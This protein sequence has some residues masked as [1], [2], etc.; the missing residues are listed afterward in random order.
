MELDAGD[1]ELT[2]E[3]NSVCLNTEDR[4]RTGAPEDAYDGVDAA[5]GAAERVEKA[6][7]DG[8]WQSVMMTARQLGHKTRPQRGYSAR[9]L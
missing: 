4:R 7:Q 9:A 2:I 3:G 8:A 5:V 1:V 6:G